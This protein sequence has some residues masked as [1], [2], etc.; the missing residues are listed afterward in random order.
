MILQKSFDT[1]E[2]S[3]LETVVLL[4]IFFFRTCDKCF[5]GFFD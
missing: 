2:L 1:D 5:R 3:V 4:D